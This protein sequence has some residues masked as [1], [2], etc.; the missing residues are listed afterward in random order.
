MTLPFFS[1][2]MPRVLGYA[3]CHPPTL[4]S[5]TA[6]VERCAY[7]GSVFSDLLHPCHLMPAPWASA[8]G[9]HDVSDFPNMSTAGVAT[10]NFGE[11]WPAITVAGGA[12]LVLQGLVLAGLKGNS[13]VGLG[14]PLPGRLRPRGFELWPTIDGLPGA[15]VRVGQMYAS[16]NA[17]LLASATAP[18]RLR[19]EAGQLQIRT[20]HT[21]NPPMAASQAMQP[22]Q[23]MP[24]APPHVHAS[25]T[26]VST[27]GRLPCMALNQ[28]GKVA[29]LHAA[30]VVLNNMLYQFCSPNCSQTTMELYLTKIRTLVGYHN[31]S[32]MPDYKT[33]YIQGSQSLQL[34]VEPYEGG[35]SQ[36]T[37]TLVNLGSAASCVAEPTSGACGSCGGCGKR[38]R[39]CRSY[40]GL[41]NN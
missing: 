27:R 6:R 41:F 19:L 18:A 29:M 24:P 25:S 5:L 11:L 30:Q 8:A 22:P 4:H 10:L 32:L 33:V 40:V 26:L 21:S 3:G 34:P 9:P 12:S 13:G 17:M 28:H 37:M 1:S 23:H 16:Q 35:P 36:G 20:G 15:E 2:E 38:R 39:F 14:L 7:C 31:A